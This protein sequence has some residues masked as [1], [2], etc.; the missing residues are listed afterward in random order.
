MWLLSRARGER[1]TQQA[2]SGALT[3]GVSSTIRGAQP[4][5]F[6]REGGICSM[7]AQAGSCLLT[8]G[9]AVLW[10]PLLL[11]SEEGSLA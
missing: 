10:S 6:F 4:L 3:P 11:G 7:K 5:R 2:A 1:T 9:S 8:P